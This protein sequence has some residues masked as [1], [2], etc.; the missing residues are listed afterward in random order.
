MGLGMRLLLDYI[1]TFQLTSKILE[2]EII[3]CVSF[4]G[5]QEDLGRLVFVAAI[6]RT[7][8]FISLLVT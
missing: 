5:E 3:L 7:D 1:Q 6:Y 2:F 4:A 8:S